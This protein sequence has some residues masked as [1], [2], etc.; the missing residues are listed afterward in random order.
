MAPPSKDSWLRAI[1][2]C[3][4]VALLGCG[5]EDAAVG[6]DAPSLPPEASATPAPDPPEARTPVGGEAAPTAAPTVADAPGAPSPES[7]PPP[8][9]TFVDAYVHGALDSIYNAEY[10]RLQ[11]LCQGEPESCW[12]ENL[13]RTPVRLAPYWLGAE[14]DELGGWLSA[15][16]ESQG[17][18]PYAALVAEGAEGT[19]AVVFEN[20]GDWGYGM[21]VPVRQ[22][23]G[24]RFQPWFLADLGAWLSLD[25]GP[26]FGVLEGP[27]GLSGR[28]WYFQA[29]ETTEADGALVTLPEGVYMV[30]GVE[31]GR[32]RFRAEIPQDMPCGEDVD[33]VPTVEV[34]V[35][36]MPVEALLDEVGRPMV[37]VA[38]PKGC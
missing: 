19:T 34:E 17:R 8:E 10:Q 5:G 28:L 30:L 11:E 35:L 21:T 6:A 36:V 25:G 29:L 15:R 7:A 14:T 23:L 1:A 32:V 26:G 31:D 20:L 38:F 37:D 12:A 13:D 27:F 2:V 16:L 3:V 18:W 24:D 9:P 22:L 4:T 33:S